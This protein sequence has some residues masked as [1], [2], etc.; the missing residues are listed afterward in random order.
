MHIN[1]NL[2]NFKKKHKNNKNQLIFHKAECKNNKTNCRW[3][4][5]HLGY[6]IKDGDV[7][8]KSCQGYVIIRSSKQIKLVLKSLYN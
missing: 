1:T 8:C 5:R 6:N 2:F 4:N 3:C 7:F